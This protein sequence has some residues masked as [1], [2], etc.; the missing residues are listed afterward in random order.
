MV[1]YNWLMRN[2]WKMFL[3]ED[4]LCLFLFVALICFLDKCLMRHFPDHVPY[5]F[6]LGGGL[7]FIGSFLGS[8]NKSTSFCPMNFKIIQVFSTRSSCLPDLIRILQSSLNNDILC[9]LLEDVLML[10]SSAI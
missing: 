8:F 1:Y 4:L 9:F 3:Q 10:L 2:F 5:F 7:K 6:R